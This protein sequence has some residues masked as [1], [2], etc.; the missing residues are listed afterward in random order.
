MKKFALF[1]VLV[2]LLS[3]LGCDLAAPTLC[4]PTSYQTL[5]A[6]G[7]VNYTNNFHF[8]EG[9]QDKDT[10]T[11]TYSDPRQG[12]VTVSDKCMIHQVDGGPTT[13]LYFDDQGRVIREVSIY[14]YD[15]TKDLVTLYT[16]DQHGRLLTKTQDGLVITYTYTDTENGSQGICQL[17]GTR[18]ELHYDSRYRLTTQIEHFVDMDGLDVPNLRIETVYH[19]D[20]SISQLNY[21]V[22]RLTT[23]R[24]VFYSQQKVS[25]E[26][27]ARLPWFQQPLIAIH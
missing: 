5:D 18:Y 26:T 7:N 27:V 23:E 3:L 16:Y 12:T 4:I 21:I 20:G 25:A 19:E 17:D 13:E 22:G 24:R 15:D 8:E 1:L 11:I 6:D 10:F 2:M 14:P 9:W